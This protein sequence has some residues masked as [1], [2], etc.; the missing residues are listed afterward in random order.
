MG[1]EAESEKAES[2]NG[3]MLLTLFLKGRDAALRRPRPRSADGIGNDPCPAYAVAPLERGADSAARCS[4]PKN[5][6]KMHSKR[7]GIC[8]SPFPL[9]RFPLSYGF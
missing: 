9:F 1:G 5:S 6:L 4:Y 3:G 8:P 7:G 2:G